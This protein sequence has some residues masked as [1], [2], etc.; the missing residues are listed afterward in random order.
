MR[1][2]DRRIGFK[3]AMVLGGALVLSGCENGLEM[4]RMPDFLRAAPTP[5]ATDPPIDDRGV[6][7]YED[8]AVI[9]ARE[10]DTIEAMAQRIETDPGVLA[11]Y[12]G[13]PLSYILRPGERLAIPSSV[14]IAAVEDGWT[15]DVVVGALDR[16]PE[17]AA[18]AP[19]P[20][21]PPGTLP[22]RHRVEP[23]ETAFSIAKLYGVSVTAL[24]SW[25]GL[26]G[27]LKVDPGR[28]LI[29]P[30]SGD[31]LPPL[32]TTEPGQ[33]T[34][35]APPPSSAEPL[36]E[37]PPEAAPIEEPNLAQFRTEASGAVKL[38]TP[39]AGQVVKP[40]APGG[41]NKNDG[42]DYQTAAG[43][44]V[45]AAADGE[46]ALVSRSLGGLGT[47]VLIRHKDDLITV[48]GRVDNVS[49]QKGDPIKRGQ[50]IGVVADD[51]P[52][53]FHFE[54][55]RGTEAVDPTPYL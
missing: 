16:V 6:I 43:A 33:T 37:N 10:N 1:G 8:F 12:N 15:P 46:V 24:A 13:L 51:A 18:A 9:V 53:T 50:T 2:K 14:Q 40:F 31:P 3:Y 38:L 29:I 55:R 17:T 45:K 36:P 7:R 21:D 26:G 41:P 48:Y 4:P 39:V 5:E 20:A 30:V 49:V 25:N 47:I 32:Q 44:S 27:D 42:I 52:P 54:V 11:R 23:G 19:A 22:V 34:A 28:S 35:V